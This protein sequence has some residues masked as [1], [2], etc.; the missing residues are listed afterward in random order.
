[1]SD[2]SS[3]SPAVNIISEGT[4]LKGNLN[5]Q[6]DIRIAG[7][8]DGE[9]ASKG[10]LIVTENG[11]I[12]GNLKSVEADIAGRVEGEVKVSNKLTL[13]KSAIIDGDIYTKTLIVEEGAQINGSC[14][15]GSDAKFL[16]DNDDSNA[17]SDSKV[18]SS[19]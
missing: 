5:S 2:S 11:K 4:K 3:H 14:R 16:S 17:V 13:R 7:H 8:V 15:M 1:M 9:A 12:V 10:K 19:S 18:K 6:T